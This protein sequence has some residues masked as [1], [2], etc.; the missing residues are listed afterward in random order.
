[1]TNP[2]ITA[3]DDIID[4]IVTDNCQLHIEQIGKKLYHM[5]ITTSS[6]TVGFCVKGSI[7]EVWRD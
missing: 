2:R 1:V 3:D 7:K 4:E 5:N 6:G